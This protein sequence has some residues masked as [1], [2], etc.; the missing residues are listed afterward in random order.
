MDS[1][2][3]AASASHRR[4]S[5]WVGM[6][7]SS[8]PRSPRRGVGAAPLLEPPERV[9]I[10]KIGGAAVGRVLGVGE[11]PGEVAVRV[12]ELPHLARVV[13]PRAA[14]LPEA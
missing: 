11:G 12:K 9:A 14:A 4:D 2:S 13:D 8:G 5:P 3:A 6:Y 7:M 10:Y 1:G